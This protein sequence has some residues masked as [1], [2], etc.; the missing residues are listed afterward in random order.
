MIPW[1]SMSEYGLRVGVTFDQGAVGAEA[2]Q[3]ISNI[4][5]GGSVINVEHAAALRTLGFVETNSAANSGIVL[6]RP[7]AG[8]RV[9]DLVETFPKATIQ[10]LE[11]SIILATGKEIAEQLGAANDALREV[12][13]PAA[14]PSADQSSA[15][16]APSS[17]PVNGAIVADPAPTQRT[18]KGA[19]KKTASSTSKSLPE[20]SDFGSKIGG[21]R[22]DL[23]AARKMGWLS[24]E[25]YKAWT[26]QEKVEHVNKSTV[27][28][29]PNYAKMVDEGTPVLVAFFI[30]RLR[31]GVMARPARNVDYD[32]Y[33]ASVSAM[34]KEM[35]TVNS[36]E[37]LS[38][39]VKEWF[40]AKQLGIDDLGH[41]IRYEL[42]GETQ[43]F[44]DVWGPFNGRRRWR[45]TFLD[46]LRDA[47]ENPDTQKRLV[48]TER[49]LRY[50]L[51]KPQNADWPN[52]AAS[53][54][55][56][57][58]KGTAGA[59]ASEATPLADPIRPH[60]AHLTRIGPDYRNG[61]DVS[62]DDFVEA[63]KFRAGEFGNWL[64]TQDRKQVFNH[65]YDGLMDLAHALN[66][67][68]D[69]LSLGGTLAV[70]FGARGRGGKGSG[71][72]HYEPGRQVMNLTKI[73]GAGALAH[74]WAHAF[75]HFVYKEY[76]G[77]AAMRPYASEAIGQT[78]TLA[79]SPPLII[80]MTGFMQ[81]IEKAPRNGEMY[82]AWL[83]ERIKKEWTYV[84]SWLRF[85]RRH[86]EETLGHE[87]VGVGSDSEIN[88]QKF[89]RMS[90]AM[91]DAHDYGSFTRA[92][93]EMHAFLSNPRLGFRNKGGPAAKNTKAMLYTVKD[94]ASACVG[95]LLEKKSEIT[96]L[97]AA[98]AEPQLGTMG[99]N[100]SDFMLDAKTL[101]ET[102]SKAYYATKW[103][104]F[105]RA[106]ESMVS[107]RLLASGV[108]SDYLVNGTNSKHGG[109]ERFTSAYP[110]GGER[111]AMLVAFDALVAQLP[112]AAM[113]SPITPAD[114][115]VKLPLHEARHAA[116]GM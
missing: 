43:G 28:P 38:N 58:T 35:S 11:R 91:H 74:E 41:G 10:Q 99:Y 86:L 108:V 31:D 97:I 22:K 72:A 83:T 65:A 34:A 1:M 51:M 107:D 16:P 21:A 44:G 104:M 56:K 88:I 70:A 17:V 67:P 29:V 94:Y 20:L 32:N 92:A 63:F 59:Q 57:P 113:R 15:G 49:A 96:R 87:S 73:Y 54:Q 48:D 66:V 78:K 50:F 24:L 39:A 61:R 45:S 69:A 4:I 100:A 18:R 27:W 40:V 42:R 68:P 85:A 77:A 106:T 36:T 110:Q 14:A 60:L 75:D 64:T 6:Q 116:M 98:G 13:E 5:V 37:A 79:G 111:K 23:A 101:D 46:L 112:V 7:L 102:K 81:A 47:A 95:N 76:F 3:H 33:V 103:E 8:F 19:A 52:K 53:H 62:E 71:A 30:K 80:A 115:T 9:R 82:L 114:D 2:A 55:R 93:I 109:T 26:A 90:Q 89:G 105:A 25:Q 84:D 12:T